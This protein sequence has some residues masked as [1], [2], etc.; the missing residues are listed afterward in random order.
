MAMN[1]IGRLVSQWVH[2]RNAAR[3]EARA[4]GATPAHRRERPETTGTTDTPALVGTGGT[5]PADTVEFTE[6]ALAR[7]EAWKAKHADRWAAGTPVETA[8]APSEDPGAG[9]TIETTTGES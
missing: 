2:D 1:G 6:A 3:F 4:H 7:F 5:A 9:E 8:P